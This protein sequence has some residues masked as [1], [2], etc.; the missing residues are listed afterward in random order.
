LVC[1]LAIQ[2]NLDGINQKDQA[3]FDAFLTAIQFVP[4]LLLSGFSFVMAKT[5]KEK[6]RKE[7]GNKHSSVVPVGELES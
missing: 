7:K 1:A 3:S 6:A 2:A 5:R 4:V